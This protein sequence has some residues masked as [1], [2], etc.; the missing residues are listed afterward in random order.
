MSRW[1]TLTLV[2]SLV[3]FADAGAADVVAMLNGQPIT[4]AD[5][6]KRTAA[7][8]MPLR[9]QE[10]DIKS[11]AV[12]AIAYERL[13]AAEAARR[14]ISVDELVRLEI[15]SRVPQP[16]EEEIDKMLLILRGRLPED[17]KEARAA[18]IE[19]LRGQKIEEREA[20]FRKEL[21]AGAK[22][23]LQLTPPRAKIALAVTDPVRGRSAAPVTLVEFS[24]FQCPYCS[25]SQETL[26]AVQKQ[27]GDRLRLAFKQ[28]PLEQIHENARV[29]AEA[30]LCANDQRKFWELHDWMFANVQ[31]L[32]RDDIVAAAPGLGIVVE[33]FSR[34]IDEHHHAKDVDADLALG[35][36]IGVGGTPAFFVNGR[37]ISGSV[38]VDTFR[39]VID[40][41][42]RSAKK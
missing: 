25:R 27:Y 11:N 32:S 21:F 42:L 37:L 7:S 29:A 34:C 39:E 41:E 8:L 9:Q 22:F 10:Y 5:I 36:Q 13:Q 4:T 3:A 12:K 40:E 17:P 18:V 6:E 20:E 19:S 15:T 28:F 2:V 33:P 38:S 23:D 16:A 31:K 1:S 26:L 35:Q 30:S 24:D 14:G